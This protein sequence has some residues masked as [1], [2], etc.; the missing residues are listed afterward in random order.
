LF[1]HTEYPSR[2]DV[3]VA[4][5]PMILSDV[6]KNSDIARECEYRTNAADDPVVVQFAASNPKDLADASEIVAR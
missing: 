4:Y 6:F 1:S 5:T 3:D 2:Y